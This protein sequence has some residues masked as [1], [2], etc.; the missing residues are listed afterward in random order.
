MRPWVP[1]YYATLDSVTQKPDPKYYRKK[2]EKDFGIQVTNTLYL[3]NDYMDSIQD[4]IK[5][6]ELLSRL[7]YRYSDLPYYILK[8][9]LENF[10]DKSL[11]EITQ[12]RY[13]RSLGANYTTYNPRRKFSLRDIVPSEIDKYFRYKKVHGYVH[14]MGAAMQGGIGGHAGVFSNANDVAKIMQLYLQ[15]GFYGGQRYFDKGTVSRFNHRYYEDKKN[16]RGIGFDKPQL[17]EEGPTC[18][19]VSDS[20]FGHSGFTGTY[21]WADP[22]SEIIYVFLA[23]R[24]YPE[25]GK[26]LLLREN[27]RTE[28]QRLIQEA[29]I[30]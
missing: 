26:N 28:I 27:I 8:D 2:K 16:R 9:Y 14:D 22:E 5:E 4:I 1:F 30:D 6:T 15:D 18:G 25:A 29:I 3:R 11:H 12:D 20:S 19:C 21:T 10:Y 24:T 13:Y 17:G 7:R 23:N